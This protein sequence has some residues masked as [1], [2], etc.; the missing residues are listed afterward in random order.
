MSCKNYRLIEMQNDNIGAVSVN[1]LMPLG[2][3]TRRIA[4]CTGSGVP[5]QVTNSGADTVQLTSKGFYNVLY[6]ATVAIG[7]A[8]SATLSLLVNGQSVYSVTETATAAGSINLTLAKCV[9]VCDNCASMSQN[10]PLDIQIQL[11]GAAITGGSATLRI[12]SCVNG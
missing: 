8:G 6:N 3:V 9:K 10:C 4:T 2:R 7:A 12:D 1:G 5:F 11:T